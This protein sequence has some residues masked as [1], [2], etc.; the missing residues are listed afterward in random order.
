MN[1]RATLTPA[2][3]VIA[4]SVTKMGSKLLNRMGTVPR[5]CPMFWGKLGTGKGIELTSYAAKKAPPAGQAGIN[6]THD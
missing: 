1:R 6:L 3:F 5:E 2:D 4:A